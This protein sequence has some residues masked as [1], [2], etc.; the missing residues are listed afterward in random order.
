MEA[1][2]RE[3]TR[4]RWWSSPTLWL[5][6]VTVAPLVVGLVL[7]LRTPWHPFIDAS[8]HELRIRDV[9]STNPPLLG[10]A[11]T[12]GGVQGEANHPGPLIFYL[13]AIPYVL[14]GG[15]SKAVLFGAGL[16]N[17]ASTVAIL[18]V[19][20]RRGGVTL[21]A[22]TAVVLA[23]LMRGSGLSSLLDAWNPWIA[24]L[25][26]VLLVLLVWSLTVGDVALAPLAAFVWS[27]VTQSHLGLAPYTGVLL[28]W[29]M[30][31]GA[32][33]LRRVWRATEP[34]ARAALARRWRWFL[35]GAVVV[36]LVCWIPPLIEQVT[37][38]DGGNLGRVLEFAT[39]DPPSDLP[40]IG[41]RAA[42][43][44]IAEEVGTVPPWVITPSRDVVY[45]PTVP[46]SSVV[47]LVVPGLAWLAAL[48]LSLRRRDGDTVRLLATVG[49]L[50]VT[51]IPTV[52]A[53]AGPVYPH[54][55]RGL[56][57]VGATLWLA[58]GWALL[59]AVMDRPGVG[60]AVRRAVVPVAAVIVG[61]LGVRTVIEA[62]SPFTSVPYLQDYAAAGAGAADAVDAAAPVQVL[63][64]GSPEGLAAESAMELELE[65]RGIQ[66]DFGEGRR[67]GSI[68]GLHHVDLTPTTTFVVGT[69]TRIP[70]LD[71]RADL[72]RVYETSVNGNP[73]VVYRAA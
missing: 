3:D 27:F 70:D 36:G 8:V 12:I 71:A 28:L 65:K 30:L 35:G 62:P 68:Y 21:L 34:G 52:A 7:L 11:A 44:L 58:V 37:A 41:R 53:I 38:R 20:R 45:I 56:W 47:G 1:G 2:T 72:T 63:G 40:K 60:E 42:L 24:V 67:A 26:F 43:E 55:V 19:A 32:L 73:V 23:L 51:T 59:Q 49:L 6:L 9:F 31:G 54:Y 66:V 15:A 46:P 14:T 61:V 16:V 22:L 33:T 5:V 10:P 13:L 25:P 69:L 39:G 4:R 57:V 64:D 17:V 18:L 50:A 48:A 29:A